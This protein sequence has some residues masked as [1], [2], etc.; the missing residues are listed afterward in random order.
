MLYERV[1]VIQRATNNWSPTLGNNNRHHFFFKALTHTTQRLPEMLERI[2][3][4]Y[5]AIAVIIVVTVII[6]KC[7]AV[8]EFIAM[9]W[10]FYTCHS[11]HALTKCHGREFECELNI[12]SDVIEYSWRDNK[13][14]QHSAI[15]IRPN[16][17]FENSN[18]DMAW[19]EYAIWVS[20]N[21]SSGSSEDIYYSIII[22]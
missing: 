12:S 3:N 22:I 9:S 11:F 1:R 4:C 14:C 8:I 19:W 10:W 2:L 7:Q 20:M 21:F 15:Q 13:M 16:F 17:S 5:K 18:W 6:V